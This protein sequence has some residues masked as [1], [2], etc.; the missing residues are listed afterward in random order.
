MV[1]SLFS[2]KVLGFDHITKV[3]ILQ[4]YSWLG[5]EDASPPVMLEA[6]AARFL[7]AAAGGDDESDDLEVIGA[8]RRDSPSEKP[9]LVRRA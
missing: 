8:E 6:G 3:R 1:W 4:I 7:L 9:R 2:L 5:Q